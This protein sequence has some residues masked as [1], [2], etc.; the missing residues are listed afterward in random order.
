MISSRSGGKPFLQI[1]QMTDTRA[2]GALLNQ[3]IWEAIPWK[4]WPQPMATTG[5]D[6]NLGA[7]GTTRAK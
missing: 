6:G 3:E 2:Q 4:A 5:G 7:R 1:T